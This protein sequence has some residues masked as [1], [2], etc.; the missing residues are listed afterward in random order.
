MNKT[1]KAYISLFKIRVAESFQYRM[2][3]F[4]GVLTSLVWAFVDVVAFTAFFRYG[5]RAKFAGGLT[6][7]Q[8][9]SHIWVREL[10]L[11]LQPFSIDDELLLKINN[12]DMG[13]EMCRPLDLYW[14]W[15]ARSSARCIVMFVMRCL[16]CFAVGFIIPGGYGA[17]SPV[18]PGAFWL[19]VP[20]ACCAF[21]LS[22][23]YGMLVTA[24]RANI[25]W[26]DGPMYFMLLIGQVLSGGYLPLQLWPNFLQPFLL[27]QPFAGLTDIPA[28]LYIGSMPLSEAWLGMGV[29]LF[30]SAAFILLGKRILSCRLRTIAAQG[31]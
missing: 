13:L 5:D 25:A 21:W 15:F 2:A 30:W 6:L 16:I 4:S 28:R 10:L 17:R 31:G 3:A 23:A 26:G 1:A 8:T 29:Q 22:S 24:V 19:F 11:F 9:I 14:H 18:S 7:E 27:L 12:G 20:S